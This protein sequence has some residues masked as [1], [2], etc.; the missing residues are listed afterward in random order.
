MHRLICHFPMV[1]HCYPVLSWHSLFSLHAFSFIIIRSF[2]WS[3]AEQHLSRT[4]DRSSSR[5]RISSSFKAASRSLIEP[6]PYFY[7]PDPLDNTILLYT[8]EDEAFVDAPSVWVARV[9]RV[10]ERRQRDRENARLHPK[11]RPRQDSWKSSGDRYNSSR[12]T[13]TGMRSR[14]LLCRR[15]L[16]ILYRRSLPLLRSMTSRNSCGRGTNM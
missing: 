4:T 6:F 5:A 1:Y 7:D 9:P 11:S 2:I 8:S 10:A 15:L 3:E 13:P 16:R 14:V 12:W